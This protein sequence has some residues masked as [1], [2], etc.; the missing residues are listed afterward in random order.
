MTDYS[1]AKFSSVAETKG[2]GYYKNQG[3]VNVVLV[4]TVASMKQLPDS[5]DKICVGWFDGN[6]TSNMIMVE[7]KLP[8]NLIGAWYDDFKLKGRFLEST[9]PISFVNNR[10]DVFYSPFIVD[11][12]ISSDVGLETI[13]SVISEQQEEPEIN[14]II[15]DETDLL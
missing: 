12:E 5:M 4:R 1:N 6:G 3:M 15:F 14:F 9:S 8:E 10:G 11:N 2:Y 7:A 13:Y